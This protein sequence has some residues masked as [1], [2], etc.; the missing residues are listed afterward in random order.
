MKMNLKYSKEYSKLRKEFL[1]N[2]VNG[3]CK[4]KIPGV[5]NHA[6]GLDLSIHHTKGRVGENLLDT[7][8]WI[9]VCLPCHDWIDRNPKKA[10]DLN[11]IQSRL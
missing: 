3:R 6:R 10:K 4:A 8:T 11:L 9:A 5:C 2:P 1:S 7:S